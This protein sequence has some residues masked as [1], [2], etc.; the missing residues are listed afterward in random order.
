MDRSKR[1]SVWN[2]FDKRSETIVVCK[3]CKAELAYSSS[4]GSMLNHMKHKHPSSVTSATQPGGQS[5][6]S[7]FVV[8][9]SSHHCRPDKANK[10]TDMIT[11]MVAIDTLPIAFVEGTGFRRLMEF[12]EPAYIPCGR[13]TITSQLEKRYK[14]CAAKVKAD[15]KATTNTALT[16][17]ARTTPTTENYVTITCHYID[18]WKLQS[19]VLQTRPTNDRHTGENLANVL[20]SAALTNC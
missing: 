7:T 4:T 6:M 13:K 14:E 8:T 20:K 19:A 15:L 11:D 3:L 12:L 2:F 1:S 17:D 9:S 10:I 5:S 18:E 16:T